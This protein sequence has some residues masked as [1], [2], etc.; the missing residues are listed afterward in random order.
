MGSVDTATHNVH[1][2]GVASRGIGK[3]CILAL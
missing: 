3:F 2:T 1:M